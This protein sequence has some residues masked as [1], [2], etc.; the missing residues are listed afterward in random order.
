MEEFVPKTAKITLIGHSVGAYIIL[1]LLRIPSIKSRIVKS[2]LLFPTIEYMAESTN[3]KL[4]MRFIRH[5][6]FVI[7]FLSWIFSLL[8]LFVQN[9]ISSIYLKLAKMPSHYVGD[10]TN[11]LQPF[12]VNNSASMALE[13]M[14]QIRERDNLVLKENVTKIKLYYA[15]SD[16]WCPISYCYDIKRDIANID[17]EICDKGFRHAFV[18]WDS[19]PMAHLIA[20][21]IMET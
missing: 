16:G 14:F 4:F 5:I 17:A 13:E 7:L 6:L 10:I 18:L 2:Y 21:W 19:I 3:G 20:E 9:S 11:F 1:K 8:P 12:T 15:V